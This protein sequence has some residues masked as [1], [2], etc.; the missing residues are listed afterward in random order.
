MHML[1]SRA[2]NPPLSL[3][4][5][6]ADWRNIAAQLAEPRRVRQYQCST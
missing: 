4:P 2:C 6:L 5:C 3:R 1:V